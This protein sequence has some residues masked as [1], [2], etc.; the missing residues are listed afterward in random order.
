MWW[1]VDVCHFK[2]HGYICD[3]QKLQS[4]TVGIHYLDSLGCE[5]LP[6]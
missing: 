1:F 4:I 3:I 6:Q 2:G 5:K